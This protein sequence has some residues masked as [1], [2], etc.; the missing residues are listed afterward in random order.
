MD[1]DG[2]RAAYVVLTTA[3]APEYNWSSGG[4]TD[5]ALSEVRFHR[6]SSGTRRD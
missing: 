1:F 3:D 4:T 5:A 6:T 2:A